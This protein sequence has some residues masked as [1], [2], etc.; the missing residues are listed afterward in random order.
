MNT[1]LQVEHPVTEMTTGI[2]IVQQQIRVGARRAAG[3]RR[4]PTSA[5]AAMRSSA[6]STPRTPRRFAPSP[7]VITRWDLPGGYGVRVDSHAG[8]GY[9]VPPY[10]DSMIAKLI[11]HGETREDALDR[12]RI[13]LD[14]MQVEGI[15][16]N[17]PLHR[18]LVRDAAF[19][20]GGVDIHHLERWLREGIR[21]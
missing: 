6:A 18:R 1:R 8:A 4:R 12:L 2:D 21:A 7:G 16:T 5:A 19:A 20:A 11:V 17:L 9:R 3:L 13:A 14:E 10:Y 15:A